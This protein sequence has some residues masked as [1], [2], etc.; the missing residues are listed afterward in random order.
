MC[1]SLFYISSVVFIFEHRKQCYY[2]LIALI[3]KF[4][5]LCHLGLVWF[6]YSLLTLDYIS[7]FFACLVFCWQCWWTP[8]IM[9]FTLL[10]AGKSVFLQTFLSFIFHTIWK[11]LDLFRSC[12][13]DWLGRTQT[14][15]SLG[16]IIP[17]LTQ[18]SLAN[19]QIPCEFWDWLS[20]LVSGNRQ[21]SWPCVP[22]S[23]F[24]S[25][26]IWFF[27]WPWVFS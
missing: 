13:E 24:P 18:Y 20:S 4:Y 12:F 10:K 26:F 19:C 8:E 7:C 1:M 9:N 5:S 21:C 11:Q 3:C 14:L 22:L 15:F 2:S 6:L 27:P 23:T 16:L 17:Q 25:N